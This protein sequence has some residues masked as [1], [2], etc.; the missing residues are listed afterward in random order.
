MTKNKAKQS[1]VSTFAMKLT[2]TKPTISSKAGG[3]SILGFSKTK[4]LRHKQAVSSAIRFKSATET[5]HFK[6]PT[7]KFLFKNLLH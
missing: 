1:L 4:F 6:T 3:E 7:L 2:F 5:F